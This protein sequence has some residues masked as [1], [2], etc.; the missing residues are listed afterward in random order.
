RGSMRPQAGGTAA[1][2]QRRLPTL[3]PRPPS[4]S[5]PPAAGQST[6]S[7]K[8][9]TLVFGPS[10]P[11]ARSAPAAAPMPIA[12][13]VPTPVPTPEPPEHTTTPDLI[14]A[15]AF[16][17]QAAPPAEQHEIADEEASPEPGTFDPAPPRGV[18]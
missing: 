2:A 18:I 7:G 13:A 10:Q 11:R 6:V 5:T 9:S 1:L 4:V 17:A 14:A 3:P 8:R 15:G 12:A 16:A